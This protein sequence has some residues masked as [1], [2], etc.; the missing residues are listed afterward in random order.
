MKMIWAI[1]TCTEPFADRVSTQERNGVSSATDVKISIPIKS[2][3]K[4]MKTARLA[5]VFAPKDEI[6]NGITEPTLIPMIR[7]N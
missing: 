4:N 1:A 5:F 7:K 3:K 2:M 6:N